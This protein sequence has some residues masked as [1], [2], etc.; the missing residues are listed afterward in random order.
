MV[1]S[2]P[3]H[4]ANARRRMLTISIPHLINVTTLA[5]FAKEKTSDFIP[6]HRSHAPLP[7]FLPSSAQNKHADG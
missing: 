2:Q 1:T 3:Q 4:P 6:A 5:Q 7:A